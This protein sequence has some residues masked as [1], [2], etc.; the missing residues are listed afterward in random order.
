M[1]PESEEVTKKKIT[2]TMARMEV[3]QLNG[4][5]SRKTNKETGMFS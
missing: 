1:E 2:T 5:L 3:T 4:K